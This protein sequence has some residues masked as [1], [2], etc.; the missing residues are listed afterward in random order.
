MIKKTAL[1]LAGGIIVVAVAAIPALAETSLN[2]GVN[3]NISASGSSGGLV[4]VQGGAGVK[5]DVK[6][7]AGEGLRVRVTTKAH[8]EIDRRIKALTDLEARLNETSKLSA[9]EKNSLS[10]EI[11]GQ[12]SAMTDLEKKID[13]D[14]ETESTSTLRADI[15]SITDSYRIF[16]LVMPQASIQAAADRAMTI[17]GTMNDLGVK[18]NARITAAQAAGNNVSASTAAMAD[19]TA[20]VSDANVQ[21][22]AA[23]SEV[24]GLTPDNGDQAKMQANLAALKDA[25]AKVQA[26]Q[27]DLVTARKDVEIV[28]KQLREFRMSASAT[29]TVSSTMEVNH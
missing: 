5:G 29:S 18:L 9:D 1:S 8:D 15:K 24:A 3:V 12:I 21:A 22:Q 10:V 13:S 20:K 6:I 11:Q 27:Q 4:N 19:F 17:V 25:R 23:I 14:S 26:S 28:L 2:A 16:L 7:G